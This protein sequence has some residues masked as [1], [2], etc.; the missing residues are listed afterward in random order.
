LLIC[1]AVNFRVAA[2]SFSF[3]LDLKPG[4]IA[5]WDDWNGIGIKYTKA[6]TCRKLFRKLI[7]VCRIWGSHTG[8][9]EE[10]FLL[11]YDAV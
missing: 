4:S 3:D 2:F 5:N 8:G 7:Y 9:Y 1:V 6:E 11:G 10:F